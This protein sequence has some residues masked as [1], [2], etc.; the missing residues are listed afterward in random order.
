MYRQ[1]SSVEYIRNGTYV[2]CYHTLSLKK[3]KKKKKK[4]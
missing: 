1:I 3:K 4:L 2:D